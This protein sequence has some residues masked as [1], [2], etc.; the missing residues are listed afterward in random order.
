[1]ADIPLSATGYRCIFN[2]IVPVYKIGI[3]SGFPGV[4]SYKEYHSSTGPG[5]VEGKYKKKLTIEGVHTISAYCQAHVPVISVYYPEYYEQYKKRRKENITQNLSIIQEKCIE[6]RTTY[7]TESF[8]I[9]KNLTNSDV[10]LDEQYNELIEIIDNEFKRRQ[11]SRKYQNITHDYYRYNHRLFRYTTIE[12]VRL[13][14]SEISV[15]VPAPAQVS[16][17]DEVIKESLID[18]LK[19]VNQSNLLSDTYKAADESTIEKNLAGDVI[20]EEDRDYMLNSVRSMLNDCVC[21]SDC[22]GYSVCW[23]YG[24][25]NYY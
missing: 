12:K 5:Y 9:L 19:Y 13:T 21:Y 15:N 11:K 6:H 8:Q 7:S 2:S 14:S 22:N 1:M 25:C 10:I 3:S 16:S 23:C 4:D 18:L 17:T 24:N 20:T